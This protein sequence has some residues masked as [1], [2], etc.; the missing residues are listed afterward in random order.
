MNITE[1]RNIIRE[2]IAEAVKDKS[3]DKKSLKKEEAKPK[4]SGKL[5]DLKKELV[6]LKQMRDD[7]Q[8]AKFA[9]KTASTEV[10]FADLQQFA[11]ELQKLKDGGV[12]LEEKIDNKINDLEEK[13]KAETSRIKEM[14]GISSTPTV[15]DENK[16]KLEE[17]KKPSA[18]MTKKEKSTVSK[19][20][21]AGKDIGK[22]GKG[23]EKVAK[24]GEKQ[25]GSKE[26]GQKVAAAAMW[27]S[28]AKK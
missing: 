20:A 19:K 8:V 18:G 9:E 1:V 21:R 28:Q 14:I 3:K 11:N 22:K 7:L 25:Y 2:V 17:K 24:A 12:A 6:A 23:F 26:A 16:E 27:K 15:V 4:S 10:E 13:I 5:I